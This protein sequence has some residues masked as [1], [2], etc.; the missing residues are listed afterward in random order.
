MIERGEIYFADLADAG[1]RPVIV[2]S[3]ELL[4]RGHYVLA[5]TC[6]TKGFDSRSK[7]RNCVPFK[8]GEF[9]FTR[10]SVAQCENLTMVE[11]SDLDL[12]SGPLGILNDTALRSLV[13]AVG[14]VIESDYEPE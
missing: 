11:K 13:K 10:D 5:V 4:N 7:L 1:R 12:N 14:Y 2:V 8:A 9:G 3:R 6:T